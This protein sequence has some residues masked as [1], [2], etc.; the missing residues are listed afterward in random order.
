MTHA[1]V[2]EINEEAVGIV[3]RQDETPTR[4]GYLFYA[5]SPRYRPIEGKIFSAPAK[6]QKAAIALCAKPSDLARASVA[7]Q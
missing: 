1:Y 6:A 3:V 2:I 7:R 4:S 5:A